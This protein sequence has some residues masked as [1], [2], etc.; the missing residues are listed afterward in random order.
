MG[1]TCA[2]CGRPFIRQ[3]RVGAGWSW[4]CPYC[5]A[6]QAGP[7]RLDVLARRDARKHCMDAIRAQIGRVSRK[8]R[9]RLEERI[10]AQKANRA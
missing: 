5:H 4:S 3:V 2:L 10:Q 8:R 7:A 9:K 6:K 1:G